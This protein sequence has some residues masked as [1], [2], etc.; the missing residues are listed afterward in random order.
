MLNSI[1]Q[2]GN[3]PV[4]GRVEAIT[5]TASKRGKVIEIPH[6]IRDRM[7]AHAVAAIPNEACGLLAGRDGGVERFYPITNVHETPRTKFELDSK[8]YLKA[9]EEME[10]GD[11]QLAGIVHSHTHTAAYPS[12]TDVEKSEGVQQFFPDA[13]FF[14]VSLRDQQPDVR[15]YVIKGAEIQEEQVSIT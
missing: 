8:E 4:Q 2:V 7:V 15:G 5:K 13:R 9:M 10:D 12:P 14:L 6:D 1:H 3:S 11:L